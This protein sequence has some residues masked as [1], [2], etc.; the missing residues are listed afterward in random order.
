V[1]RVGRDVFQVAEAV[2]QRIRVEENMVDSISY[3]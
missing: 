2:I 1:K 3:K